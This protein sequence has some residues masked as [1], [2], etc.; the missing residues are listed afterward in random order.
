M[1]MRRSLLSVVLCLQALLRLEAQVFVGYCPDDIA[2]KGIGNANQTATVSCAAAF[3]ADDLLSAY[4]LCDLGMVRVG[5]SATEGISSFRVWVREH[6]DADNLAEV[7]VEVSDLC[8]GW[9]TVMLPESLPLAGHD[10]L[11]CGYDYTQSQS[12]VSLVSHAGAKKTPLSFWI[13]NNGKWR[14]Y[15]SKYGPLSLR[16]GIVGHYAHAVRLCD[17]WLDLRCQPFR[18]DGQ[19][20]TPVNVSGTIQN[21]GRESLEGDVAFGQYATFGYS[22]CPGD[23]VEAPASDIA[24][25][26]TLP[27]PAPDAIVIDGE[28]TLYYD[29]YDAA[30]VNEATV[31]LVEEFTSERNGFAPLGQ[32]RLREALALATAD[33]STR[34]VVVSHHEGFG[35]ADPWRVTKGSDYDASLFGPE[36]LTF[37]PAALV[38]REGGAFSTTLPVDSLVALLT[39]ASPLPAMAAIDLEA[40]VSDGLVTAEVGVRPCAL[41]FCANPQLVLCLTQA[42]VASVGQKNYYPDLVDG[43]RQYDV[44]RCFLHNVTGSDALLQGADMA[45][46]MRG[47]VRVADYCPEGSADRLTYRYQAA[48]PDGLTSLEGCTLVAYIYDRGNTNRVFAVACSTKHL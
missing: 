17:L 47:Q 32:Q 1:M 39:A 31:T 37:A 26:F 48:L 25:H 11:Y 12:N 33:P 45:E 30:S 35:P 43:D 18:P 2:A 16:A 3:T 36:R 24:H 15:T 38:N 22:F 10:T 41:T 14:D 46:V 5:L 9:N 34:Y 44:V 8:I 40:S 4:Q 13:A 42:E 6:L 27:A 28:R 20:Y 21:I 7:D 29:L 23:G 19:G